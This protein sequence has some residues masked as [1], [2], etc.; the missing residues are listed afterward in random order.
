[1]A[2]LENIIGNE[3][4]RSYF[5][6]AIDSGNVSHCYVISGEKGIGKKMLAKSFAQALLC[7]SEGEK[8]CMKCHSCVQFMSKNHPDVIYPVHEKQS[9]IGVDDVRKGIIEHIQI[10][11]YSSKYKI[12]IVDEAEKL[13]IQ[14]QN[15]LLKTIEEPPSYGVLILLTT[16]GAGLL[17]TIRSRSI[18]LTMRPLTG[19]DFEDYLEKAG[20][21]K[22][23]IP[24]LVRFAQGNIGK[25]M[26]LAQA[27][28]FSSM[29]NQIMDLLKTADS[30]SFEG[31]L[32]G[33]ERLESYKV[34]IKDC[35]AFIRMWY[36]DVLMYKATGDPNLLIFTEELHSL[37]KF[38]SRYSYNGINRILEAIDVTERRLDAN[39][40]FSLSMELLWLTIRDGSKP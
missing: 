8:P 1:M 23:K 37:R 31:L 26:K 38:A 36:R 24:S 10:K 6:R 25:A 18:M 28:D 22:N 7:E 35:L 39:V 32:S 3:Q 19:D 17:D 15:A 13:S 21:E 5:R 29:V 16:N 34:D 9:V 30:L 2:G 40:N 11:P 33:I 27:E 14:A 20:I 4:V 12:Y